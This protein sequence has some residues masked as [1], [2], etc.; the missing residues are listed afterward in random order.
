MKEDMQSDLFC[1]G[2]SVPGG[3]DLIELDVLDGVLLQANLGQRDREK[4]K[5]TVRTSPCLFFTTSWAKRRI[6]AP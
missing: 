4:G 3:L 1:G 2:P 6:P 5:N